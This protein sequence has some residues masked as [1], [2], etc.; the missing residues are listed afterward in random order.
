M[1]FFVKMLV[2]GAWLLP[3]GS[4]RNNNFSFVRFDDEVD[5][6]IRI[7][8]FIGNQPL[9]IK[10]NHQ[11]FGLILSCRCPA[12]RIKRKGLPKPSTLTWILVLKPPMLRPKAC[13]A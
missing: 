4:W 13:A 5:K 8:A 10:V 9:K 1:A 7:I 11:R 2:I 6:V 3:F 12:V